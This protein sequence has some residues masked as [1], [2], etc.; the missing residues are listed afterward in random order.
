LSAN[1]SLSEDF[2]NSINFQLTSALPKSELHSR[3]IAFL[4]SKVFT[5]TVSFAVSM[6]FSQTGPLSASGN[7]EISDLLRPSVHISNTNVFSPSDNHKI[8]N[9]LS[10]SAHFS[11][12]P[13]FMLSAELIQSLA[14]SQSDDLRDKLAPAKASDPNLGLMIGA[15]IGV[16]ILIAA[17]IGGIV[18][19]AVRKGGASDS[20]HEHAMDI[21]RS[22]WESMSFEQLDAGYLTQVAAIADTFCEFRS[23]ND[24]ELLNTFQWDNL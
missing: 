11:K 10:R 17:A 1:C 19:C 13:I 15:G 21:E 9:L 16:V 14:F 20:S 6:G 24:E 3:S 4:A 23:D 7:H 18:M 8:S 2:L 5:G 12:T 22:Q